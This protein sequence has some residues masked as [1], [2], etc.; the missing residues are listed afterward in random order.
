MTEGGRGMLKL[1]PALMTS[2]QACLQSQNAGKTVVGPGTNELDELLYKRKERAT[3]LP[4]L[5]RGALAPPVESLQNS[6][7][8]RGGE[9]AIMAEQTLD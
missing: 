7:C 8:Q 4:E 3:A 1:R 6:C 2:D 5:G 9:G